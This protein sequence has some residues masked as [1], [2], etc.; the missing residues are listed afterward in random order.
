MLAQAT[1]PMMARNQTLPRFMGPCMRLPAL[2]LLVGHQPSPRREMRSSRKATHVRAD[3]TQNGG[4]R[5]GLDARYR[6]EQLRRLLKRSE[7]QLDLAL[8]FVNCLRQEVDV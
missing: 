5:D 4:T 6:L 2:S 3:L 8:H 7:A 1:S